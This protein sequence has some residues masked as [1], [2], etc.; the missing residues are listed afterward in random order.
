VTAA[1]F[2]KADRMAEQVREESR[3]LDPVKVVLTVLM[4]VPFALGWT[5]GIVARGVWLVVAWTWTAAVVGWR[6]AWARKQE[7]PDGA[8]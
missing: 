2:A 5:V 7:E 8:S 6:T 4:V 1:V 3:Q